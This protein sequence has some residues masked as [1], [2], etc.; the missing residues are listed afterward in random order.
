M[1]NGHSTVVIMMN[2]DL[3]TA[4][5]QGIRGRGTGKKGQRNS[6]PK[7]LLMTN[8]KKKGFAIPVNKNIIGPP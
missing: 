5:V 1:I 7:M 3:A 2:G 4:T 6:P 8:R